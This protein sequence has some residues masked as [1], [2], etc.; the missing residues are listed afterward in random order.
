MH[1]VHKHAACRTAH[2][3]AAAQSEPCHGIAGCAVVCAV[4]GMQL[5]LAAYLGSHIVES[6]GY[7]CT[8]KEVECKL[9]IKV[10]LPAT[11]F[12]DLKSQTAVDC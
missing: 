6:G 7:A 3:D 2:S 1:A 11:S 12:L 4:D 10:G 5:L 8:A 9:A